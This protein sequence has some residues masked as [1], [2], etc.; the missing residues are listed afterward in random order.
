MLLPHF[1]NDRRE[2]LYTL[3]VISCQESHTASEQRS[4]TA[5]QQPHAKAGSQLLDT[6]WDGGRGAPS[7]YNDRLLEAPKPR[8]N[9]PVSH[10]PQCQVRGWCSLITPM[11]VFLNM[12]HF[13]LNYV[14]TGRLTEV[15]SPA[16]GQGR[17]PSDRARLGLCNCKN[18]CCSSISLLS[19]YLQCWHMLGTGETLWEMWQS[20]GPRGAETLSRNTDF[21]LRT[22]Q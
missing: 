19:K 18:A 7:M 12:T 11:V 6:I 3:R 13:W 1:I 9:C 14:G 22:V 16:H 2:L 8:L 20:P 17:S 10:T 4:H 5:V 15:H 21:F